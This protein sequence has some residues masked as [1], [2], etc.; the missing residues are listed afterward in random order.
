MEIDNFDFKKLL[1]K[2]IN[3]CNIFDFQS[4]A[5]IIRFLVEFL[6]ELPIVEVENGNYIIQYRNGIVKKIPENEIGYNYYEKE[7]K[8]IKYCEFMDK[9]ES[10]IFYV[11]KVYSF[12]SLSTIDEYAERFA[13]S[14]ISNLFNGFS[15]ISYLF[16]SYLDEIDEDIYIKRLIIELGNISSKYLFRKLGFKIFIIVLKSFFGPIGFMIEYL[17]TSYKLGYSFGELL[18]SWYYD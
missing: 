13:G 1:N 4:W 3:K 7:R 2:I 15:P 12:Y 11:F 16:K 5:K 8:I 9:I 6:F 17:V 10:F 18:C 14:T